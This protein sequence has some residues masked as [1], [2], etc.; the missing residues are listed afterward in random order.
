MPEVAHASLMRDLQLMQRALSQ[1]GHRSVLCWQPQLQTPFVLRLGTVT[2][3]LRHGPHADLNDRLGLLAA[4]GSLRP[5]PPGDLGF[6]AHEFIAPSSSGLVPVQSS[7]SAS[8]ALRAACQDHAAGRARLTEA[9]ADTLSTR[10]QLITATLLGL[11]AGAAALLWAGQAVTG[12]VT[13]LAL[14]L[15]LTLV[16]KLRAASAE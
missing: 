2:L 10:R 12:V 5:V 3:S 6:Y 8:E 1:G 11:L 14:A 15:V 7:G 13:A 16:L 4:D 9:R